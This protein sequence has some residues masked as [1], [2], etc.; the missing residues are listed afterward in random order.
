MNGGFH[1][2]LAEGAKD[3]LFL[4]RTRS[5][6]GKEKADSSALRFSE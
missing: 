1:T 4:R 3:L 6:A 2:V 5:H